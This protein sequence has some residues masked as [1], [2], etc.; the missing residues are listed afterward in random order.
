MQLLLSNKDKWRDLVACQIG[1]FTYLGGCVHAM[2][3]P[4]P[5]VG[6]LL[7]I[8]DVV[9]MV[10]PGRPLVS[11]VSSSRC[12]KNELSSCTVTSSEYTVPVSSTLLFSDLR[13][14]IPARA[15]TPAPLPANRNEPRISCK[16]TPLRFWTLLHVYHFTHFTTKM[17]HTFLTAFFTDNDTHPR[18]SLRLQ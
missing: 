18:K 9:K 5:V 4:K 3:N 12:R 6:V 16:N 8:F 17:Q 11:P 1:Y 13:A 10:R 2:E 14:I 7:S 15:P